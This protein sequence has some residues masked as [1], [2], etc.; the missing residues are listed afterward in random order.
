MVMIIYCFFYS[1]H[2]VKA[3]ISKIQ[4]VGYSERIVSANLNAILFLI[5]SFL[6]K[7][8]YIKHFKY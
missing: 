1:K 3:S 5:K 7:M 6:M 4:N 8:E 2:D